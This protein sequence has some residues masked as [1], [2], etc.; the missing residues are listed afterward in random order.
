MYMRVII[1][2]EWYIAKYD[3]GRLTIMPYQMKYEYYKTKN[4]WWAEKPAINLE[5]PITD[6]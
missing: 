3:I 5:S 4:S 2:I 1:K 6:L